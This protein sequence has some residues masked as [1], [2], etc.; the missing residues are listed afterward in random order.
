MPS[1]FIGVLEQENL[2]SYV[3]PELVFEGMLPPAGTLGPL[4][5]AGG[6]GPCHLQFFRM[7]LLNAD[8]IQRGIRPEKEA[9]VC[10]PISWRDRGDRA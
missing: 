3:R 7:T 6:R 9:D 2:I 8:I 10:L 5:A 4:W 1:G